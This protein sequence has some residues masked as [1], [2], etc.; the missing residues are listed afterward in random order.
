MQH[1]AASLDRVVKGTCD[2]RFKPVDEAFERNF[3]EYGEVGAAV[4]VYRKGRPVVDLWGG[5]RD[6][7]RRLP[8]QSDTMVCM[9][10]V[11]KGISATA[12]AMVVRSR[13]DR[14]LLA[15]RPLLAGI[16]AGRQG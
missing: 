7:A 12:M 13:S 6:G 14:P 5:Y 4:A 9:M 15:R 1:E 16:R 10:S 2:P 8:W 3:Q 11:A